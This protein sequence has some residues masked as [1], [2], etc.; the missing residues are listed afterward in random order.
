MQHRR[1]ISLARAVRSLYLCVIPRAFSSNASLISVSSGP[2]NTVGTVRNA[3][4]MYSAFDPDRDKG[5]FL[6]DNLISR[7]AR[8]SQ[9]GR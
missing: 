7:A 5:W 8:A 6:Y 2:L 1:S 3:A 9:K 4:I